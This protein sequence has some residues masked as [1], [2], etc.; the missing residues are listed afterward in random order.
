MIKYEPTRVRQHGQRVTRTQSG[1][2]RIEACRAILA[3]GSFAKIDGVT[4]D[5]FSASAVIAVYDYL[6]ADNK[7]K[8]ERLPIVKMVRL[9]FKFV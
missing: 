3:T 6:N 9:A 5:L 1:A 2:E 8:F 7:A 4:V